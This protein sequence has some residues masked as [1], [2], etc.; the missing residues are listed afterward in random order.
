MNELLMALTV[1]L[2]MLGGHVVSDAPASGMAD[3]AVN[4]TA[5]TTLLISHS[6]ARE[7]EKCDLL[8]GRD[9]K[10]NCYAKATGDTFFCNRITDDG[11][12]DEC[13]KA[14]LN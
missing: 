9:A 7:L 11:L 5:T 12:K 14:V 2:N 1:V 4:S 8:S 13:I 3:V 6:V 10:N